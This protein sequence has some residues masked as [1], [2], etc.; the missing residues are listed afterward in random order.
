MIRPGTTAGNEIQ[1]ASK[2]KDNNA[3]M[4]LLGFLTK[5]NLLILNKLNKQQK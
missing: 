1:S 3:N 4:K 5:H 2:T